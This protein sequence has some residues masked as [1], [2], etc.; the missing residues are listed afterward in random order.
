MSSDGKLRLEKGDAGDDLR[1]EKGQQLHRL[2]GGRT[3]HASPQRVSHTTR[4]PPWHCAA[5]STLPFVLRCY[6]VCRQKEK[7]RWEGT[8]GET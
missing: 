6:A 8:R 7:D 4:T 5:S 3:A 1:L 2:C